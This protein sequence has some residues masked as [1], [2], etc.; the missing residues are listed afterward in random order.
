MRFTSLIIAYLWVPEFVYQAPGVF[1]SAGG[2]NRWECQELT[3]LKGENNKTQTVQWQQQI[4]DV[5]V[6]LFEFDLFS[7]PEGEDDLKK[8]QLMELAILN[9]TYRDQKT[10]PMIHPF[11]ARKCL[12]LSLKKC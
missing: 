8:K 12:V 3:K 6:F 2:T 5:N 11:H 10:I 9:G 4:A 7:Q 1:F